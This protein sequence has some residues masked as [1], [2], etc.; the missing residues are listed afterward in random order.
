MI[1]GTTINLL[2]VFMCTEIIVHLQRKTKEIDWRKKLTIIEL[3]NQRYSSSLIFG[4][5]EIHEI[6]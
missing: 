2:Y 3:L 4:L 5:Q 6:S 1:E